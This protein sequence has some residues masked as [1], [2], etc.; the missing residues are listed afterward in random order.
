MVQ[1]E[2]SKQ[3]AVGQDGAS[4]RRVFDDIT[5][6]IPTVGRPILRKCLQSVISGKVLP[7]R[8]VIVDQ[9][10]NPAVADWVDDI[11][12][13]GLD[14]FHLRSTERSPASARNR[15]IEQVQTP[16]MAT[17]DDDCMAEDDWLEKLELHLQKDPE[18]IVTGR[19]LLAGNRLLST[20]AT[21]P[22]IASDTPRLTRVPSIRHPFQLSAANMGISLRIAQR[23][24]KFDEALFTAEDIDWGHR[25]LH[26]GIPIRYAPEV[27]VH[28][29][30]WRDET[31][32]VSNYR[33]Y[34]EGL[35]AFYGKY[36]RRGEWSMALRIA[37]SLFRGARSV[38]YGVINKDHNRRVRGLANVIWLLP[39]VVSGFLNLGRHRER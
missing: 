21:L 37:L 11:K 10:D 5:V 12:G 26:A 17:I 31:Q 15:G 29:Y 34:A 30:H 38:F 35:G 16:F 36:L 32:T 24:G 33:A 1:I 25:A 27:T 2:H 9:G 6:V 4:S 13:V 19:V 39:G 22:R 20:S 23:I 14:V 3:G 8:I 18:T 28:H 7:A